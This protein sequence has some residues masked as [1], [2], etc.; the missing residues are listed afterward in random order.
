MSMSESSFPA[1]DEPQDAPL[2]PADTPP[3]T[4]PDG[5][6]A[7]GVAAGEELTE[8]GDDA[9]VED[10]L[11]ATT[12]ESLAG[13]D[14]G[15][16]PAAADGSVPDVTFPDNPGDSGPSRAARTPRPR[17][18]SGPRQTVGDLFWSC[19]RERGLA[20]VYGM[21][22][23]Q[24]VALY[25]ALARTTPAIPHYLVRHEQGAT[26]LAAGHARATG[27]IAAALIVPGPGAANAA[28]GLLDALCD[29][30]PVLSVVGGYERFCQGKDPA[31]LF[32]GLDQEAFHKP[33]A[34]YFASPQKVKDI[35]RVIDGAF[36]AMRGVRPGPAVIELAPDFA[37]QPLP[38]GYRP[39]KANRRPQPLPVSPVDLG[40]A[41]ELMRAMHRPV[42]WVGGDCEAAR[43]SHRVRQLAELL[44]APVVY[45][46]RGKGVL[47]DNHRQVAGF[48]RS[49]RV[50]QL[51][52]ESD[53]LIAIGTRFTQIDTRNWETP[54]PEVV[55]RFDRDARE[56]TRDA[57][58]TQGVSG[59]LQVALD[60]VLRELGRAPAQVEAGWRDR[61]LALHTA[62]RETPPPPVLAELAQALPRGGLAA[63]DVTATGYNCF[64]RL[65]VDDS[66]SL[67]YPSHSV[68][69]GYAFPAAVG[70][71]LAAP[72]RPVVSLSGDAGFLMGLTE[73]A[74]AVQY[75]AAVVAVV[76]KDHCLTAILGSQRQ[77]CAGREVDTRMPS[78]D[79]VAVAR[80]FG[81]EGVACSQLAELPAL[82]TAGLKR[83][84][85]TVI[86]LDL[87]DRVDELIGQIPWLQGE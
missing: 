75:Q 3:G 38:D 31:K 22:G 16:P 87:S 44:G 77:A 69:L 50:R 51:L 42:I 30:I 85:P 86:E 18:E 72:H 60:A 74:T 48:T 70:A 27:K 35:P 1:A 26:M 56:V 49:V 67:I 8:G 81:A 46:R 58:V 80:A 43:A 83:P 15:E 41:I 29:N 68:A 6:T 4:A 55:V 54:L 47:P 84:G 82:I 61:T 17:R 11:D 33:L 62:W 7:P 45:G 36:A 57:P 34:K 64:D 14:T 79:F 23:N 21:P 52:A 32:H 76:V 73:L 59:D 66:R 65:F 53:G 25:D 19:L 2:S 63:I 10:E 9:V 40:R 39:P 24:N 12:G 28:T 13:D 71:K 78:P 5:D 37:A 20:A